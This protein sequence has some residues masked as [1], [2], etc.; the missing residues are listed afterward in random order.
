[1][2]IHAALI[3]LFLVLPG[4]SD[5][6][7]EDTF[8]YLPDP[9]L[10]SVPGESAISI[11]AGGSDQCRGWPLDLG[12]P[13]AGFPYTPTLQDIDGDGAD[14]IF[15]TGGE[16]FG[17][18]GD[19]TFLPGWPTSDHDYM[20]YGTNDQM[21]GP[22][23]WDLEGD[24]DFE[25][26]W[27]ERDWWAGS[28]HMW[29]FNGREASG[30]D[31][32]GFPQYAPDDYSNALDSPF[33]LG[34][35]D[36]DGY[37]EAWSAHTLGNNF[38]YYRISGFDHLG[39]RMFTTDLDPQESVIN[40]YFGDVDGNGQDEFFAVSLLS[41]SIMLHAFDSL[42]TDQSGY[43]VELLQPTGTLMF[44][45]PIPVDLDGDGDLEIIFG[46]YQSSVSYAQARHHDGSQVSG[47][48]FTIAS[49]S[50][51]FYLGLGDLSGDGY[52]ELI[53][54]DNFL[55]GD[56][57]VWA[58]YLPS[59]ELLSGW[60]FDVPD[61]PE[62]FPTVVDVDDNG[63]Q[64][65]CFVT[66]GGELYAVMSNGFPAAGFPKTLTGPSISGVA[67]GDIDGDDLYELVAVTW[68]GWAHAWDTD[69]SVI[70]GLADWPMR[71]IDPR[72]TGVF[73]CSCPSGNPGEEEP[74]NFRILS[75]PVQGQAEFHLT[76]IQSATLDIFDISG[77]RV[78]SVAGSGERIIWDSNGSRSGIY[79]AVLRSGAQQL[80][81][82]EFVL[83]R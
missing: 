21:P 79:F 42:G 39:N 51:L 58:Y 60:P 19:G 83:L 50:Q 43:P 69:G 55:G 66:G 57:R 5:A 52:P 18:S 65:V 11:S 63:Y 46:Y 25:I 59:G 15:C 28:S 75:N 76:G 72:N 31:M 48:P 82:V 8:I 29:S 34:D 62:G 56:Y 53:A 70:S 33:V 6:M 20:G 17:I 81:E 27:S 10:S 74:V 22:S 61:W 1:M 13:G 47:F 12:A 4:E 36:D 38:T 73:H 45:P 54:F 3:F 64:D 41:G 37:L 80:G 44:G 7:L 71:G 2:M 32:T 67:A 78:A 49:T 16:T 68:D 30:A 35:S 23:C 40:L 24:G 26:M 14:E 77:R 9:G